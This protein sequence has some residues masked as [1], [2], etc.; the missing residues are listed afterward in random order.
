MP[1]GVPSTPV[2]FDNVEVARCTDLGM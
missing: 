2:A 1:T